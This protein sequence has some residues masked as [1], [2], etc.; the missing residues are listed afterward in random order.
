MELGGGVA[1]R[2]DGR[3]SGPALESGG[4]SAESSPMSEG[5]ASSGIG[6]QAIVFRSCS[7]KQRPARLEVPR[8][9]QERAG[10]YEE[11]DADRELRAHPAFPMR[12]LQLT[13][14]APASWCGTPPARAATARQRDPEVGEHREKLGKLCLLTPSAR[15]GRMGP[16]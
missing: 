2:V 3:V 14:G 4:D 9:R 11:I 6:S 7:P 5:S 15:A 12:A 1:A 16:Q 13:P 8:A 10:P